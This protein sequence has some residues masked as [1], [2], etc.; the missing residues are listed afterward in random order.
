M[1]NL[2]NRNIRR[3]QKNGSNVLP[4]REG[5]SSQFNLSFD[6]KTTMKFD[7]LYPV[8]CEELNPGDHFNINLNTFCRMNPTVAPVMDNCRINFHAFFVPNR[9]LWEHWVNFMGEKTWQDSKTDY[10]V[11]HAVIGN[12]ERLSLADYFGIPPIKNCPEAVSLLPFR[13][14]NKIWNWYFRSIQVEEPVK[15]HYTDNYD[16]K[17]NKIGTETIQEYK[18]LKAGKAADYFTTCLP[19][20]N[21][22]DVEIGLIGSAD[23]YFNG[24][25]GEFVTGKDKTTGKDR[26]MQKIGEYAVTVS[27]PVNSGAAKMYAD[28]SRVTGVSIEMLRYANALQQIKE[29]EHRYGERYPEIMHAHWGVDIPEFMLDKPLYLGRS[30]TQIEMQTIAQTSETTQTSAQGTITAVGIGSDSSEIVDFSCMEHGQL[31]ILAVASSEV[32]YQQGLDR[33]LYKL[34]KYDY[35]F[36][37]FWNLGDQ[38]VLN[39]ELYLSGDINKN[40]EVFGYQ[41]RYREYREGV[42]KIT[43]AMRTNKE[44]VGFD[45]YQLSP[46]YEQA[47]GL[48][49]E[50][51]R[52]DTPIARVLTVPDEEA[53]LLNIEFDIKAERTLTVSGRP[54]IIAGQ[55]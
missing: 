17:T 15:E 53:L 19:T 54:N 12:N 36:P 22:Q 55:L 47:P 38:P 7:Y 39:K 18:L 29:L 16:Y 5:I 33:K 23:V 49:T 42:N 50:F 40:N 20:P 41:E 25:E 43:G 45:V 28:M 3:A 30:T 34:K 1:T 9:S 27:T 14:Y 51:L 8:L 44:K 4:D 48:N 31:I 35:L 46:Y 32:N 24:S 2:N 52:L 13:A 6:L 21:G 26:A 10:L 37:A 11:P